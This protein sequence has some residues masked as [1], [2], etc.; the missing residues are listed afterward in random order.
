MTLFNL[1]FVS[2]QAEKTA[3]YLHELF[4]END[5]PEIREEVSSDYFSK[6]SGGG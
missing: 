3:N 6:I 1:S 2:F 5:D 4:I